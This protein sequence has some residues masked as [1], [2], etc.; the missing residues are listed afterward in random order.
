M[1]SIVTVFALFSLSALGPAACTKTKNN[2][3]NAP[4][5]KSA[6][7]GSKASAAVEESSQPSEQAK[8]ATTEPQT[9]TAAAESTTPEQK[10]AEGKAAEGKVV[11]LETSMGTITIE[12][13]PDKAPKTVA[14]FLQYVKDGHYDGTIFHRV[15][16]NFMI[17]GGGFDASLSKKPVRAPIQNEADNGLKNDIGTVAMARTSD[18]HSASAQ[19]FINTKDNAFLNFRNKTQRGWGYTVFGRVSGGMDVVRKISKVATGPK[20]PFGK[21][22]P[23]EDVV[24]ESA[25][26]VK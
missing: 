16:D 2:A 15:I 26:I 11:A 24:I 17:Q 21:D 8:A 4:S 20:G 12:L 3:S 6:A 18:P 10:V 22:V 13:A 23:Q 19:F 14:N 25:K 7:T 9:K 5:S 1:R